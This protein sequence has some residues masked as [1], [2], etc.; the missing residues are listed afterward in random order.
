MVY[1]HKDHLLTSH[2]RKKD[3]QQMDK[4]YEQRTN[5]VDAQNQKDKKRKKKELQEMLWMIKRLGTTKHATG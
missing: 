3:T 4:H 1:S 5:T 2:L